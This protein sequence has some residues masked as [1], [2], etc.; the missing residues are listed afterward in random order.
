[1]SHGNFRMNIMLQEIYPEHE[2]RPNNQSYDLDA[3]IR[4]ELPVGRQYKTARIISRVCEA[5]NGYFSANEV[6]ERLVALGK[7]K[8][9]ETFGDMQKW[10]Y[11]EVRLIEQAP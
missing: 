1:M 6:A 10:A 2:T 3:L 9:V 5:T 7:S 4:K 8:I 11:S